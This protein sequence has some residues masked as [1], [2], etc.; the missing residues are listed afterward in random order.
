VRRGAVP[1]PLPSRVGAG[2]EPARREVAVAD[3]ARVSVDL[4]GTHLRA[5]V[6]EADGRVH[7]HRLTD[8][9]A[10]SSHPD[11]VGDLLREVAEEAGIARGVV[12]VP[13]PVDYRRGTLRAAPNLPTT[14]V[15]GL[16]EAALEARAGFP[17]S[18]ANDADLAAVGEAFFGAGRSAH[19][20]AYVTVSTGVGAGVVLGGR[21]VHGRHS[22]AELGHVVIDRSALERGEPATV[23]D[24]GSGTAMAR[25]AAAL[26]APLAGAA[27]AEAVAAG[28]PAARAAWAEAVAAVA[29]G[30]LDL[31][32]LFAPEVVVLGGGV[33]RA[34]GFLDDVRRW[35]GG[36]PLP[37]LGDPPP[38]AV[39][40]L[41]D[42]AGLVGA[43]AWDRAF[44]PEAAG[45]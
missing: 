4:G 13:G 23:E 25:R 17:I 27:L 31:S 24:L 14:W 37:G 19:D 8:T 30:I 33:G 29:V 21:L 38:L 44:Q 32:R 40:A 7:S 2:D 15:E 43:A 39:A 18:L 6:V 20:V 26:G 36:R 16:S 41:G 1:R 3:E 10:G 42:D 12:G 22:L 28:V 45:R 9:P 34:V 35:W 5:A 11:A